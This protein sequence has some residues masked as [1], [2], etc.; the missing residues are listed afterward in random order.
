MPRPNRVRVLNR[1][2][3]SRSAS[4]ASHL[5]VSST[6]STQ[7][8]G[9]E[10]EEEGSAGLGE[11]GWGGFKWGFG[12]FSSWGFGRGAA[13]VGIGGGGGAGDGSSASANFPSKTDFARN[14]AGGEADAY[15]DDE[16]DDDDYYDDDDEDS[17]ASSPSDEEPLYPGLYR[18]LYAFEPEG[19]AEMKLEEEQV[20]RVIGRGGGVGWA[21]VER[22][23]GADGVGAAA[24][25][26][27]KLPAHALVPESYLEVV[28]LDE[29]EEGDDDGGGSA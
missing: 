4:N 6:S 15:R 7:D 19:T 24:E 23:W 26:E 28:R 8:D 22:R 5:S 3:R 20:V 13:A 18:A 16:D 12:R 21:V 29:E 9:E 17:F 2:H 10:E 25:E 27:E 1:F 14:F 11:D